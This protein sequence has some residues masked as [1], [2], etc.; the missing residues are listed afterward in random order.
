MTEAPDPSA[1][2][3]SDEPSAIDAAVAAS[4]SYELLKKR[5]Q[6]QGDALLAKAQALNAARLQA[7]GQQEQHLLLRTRARTEHACVARDMVRIGADRVLLGFNV[8]LGLR[9]ETGV[10]DVF[11]LYELVHHDQP[12]EDDATAPA[13]ELVP[14]PLADSFLDDDRFKADF[15]ELYTYYKQATLQMLRVTNDWLLAAFQIGA[16]RSDIRVFEWGELIKRAKNGEHDLVFMGWAGDNGDPDNFLT[17]NLSCAAAESG[18]NQ[19]G[20]CHQEF[21]QLIR[22]ARRVAEPERRAALYREA[23]AIFHQQAPW[24]ALA[25]PKQFAVL[26]KDVEGFVLSPLGS[27]NFTHVKRKP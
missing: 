8:F 1:P 6:T 10:G 11:A 27:N 9:R 17:P 18:E 19:A 15:S 7:F 3:S 13:D 4:S 25:H 23:L 21:D 16:Q 14:L 5:L 12:P 22:E 20:W 26:R 24:I 2:A